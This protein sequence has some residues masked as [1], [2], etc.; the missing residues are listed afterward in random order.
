MCVHACVCVCLSVSVCLHACA[1]ACMCGCMKLSVCIDV[2]IC[3][4]IYTHSLLSKNLYSYQV[5][6]V[7]KL[8]P[9]DG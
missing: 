4:N 9:F 3:N 2:C 8:S 7:S 5:I 6:V 1:C